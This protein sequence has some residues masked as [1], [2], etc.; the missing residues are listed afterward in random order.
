VY[1]PRILFARFYHP[2]PSHD[3]ELAMYVRAAVTTG[4]NIFVVGRTGEGKSCFLRNYVE[5]HER[6]EGIDPSQKRSPIH[7]FRIHHD[8]PP[9]VLSLADEDMVRI[10]VKELRQYLVSI[11]ATANTDDRNNITPADEYL[12]LLEALNKLLPTERKSQLVVVVDDIDHLPQPQQERFYE[13]LYPLLR[14]PGCVCVVAVRPP[15][16]NSA[17]RRTTGKFATV[18]TTMDTVF[19]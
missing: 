10:V 19:L 9:W 5:Q 12:M 13:V 16:Y 1:A 4:R 6:L 18:F 14:S 17:R 3:G 15:A 7:Y 2:R 11:G 8:Q